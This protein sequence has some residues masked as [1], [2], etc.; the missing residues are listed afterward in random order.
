MALSQI[1]AAV[2]A[3]YEQIGP[4]AE[5]RDGGEHLGVQDAPPRIVWV[6][7]T[8]AFKAPRVYF[9]ETTTATSAARVL[10]QCDATVEVHLWG[11]TRDEAEQMRD[12]LISALRRSNA[13][14]FTVTRGYWPEQDARVLA[15]LG[16][17]YILEINFPIP[18]PEV[19]GS[20]TA[21]TGATDTTDAALERG[22]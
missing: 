19:G 10:M 12:A 17:R 1:F 9:D 16:R 2:Q 5:W 6:P 14:A 22:V 13:A 18:V 20:A 11:S 3:E 15:Q 4:A 8:D 21:A 7:T